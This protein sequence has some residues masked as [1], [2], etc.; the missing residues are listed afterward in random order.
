MGTETVV[1]DDPALTAR[2]ADDVPVARQPLRVVMG[3]RELDPGRRV[4][5]TAAETVVI[6]TRDPLAALGELWARGCRRVLLEGGPT[7]AAAFL[8]AG[9]VDEVIVYIAPKFLGAGRAA[10][11]DLGVTTISEA[12]EGDVTDITVL[13]SGAGEAPNVRITLRPRPR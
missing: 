7:I 6:R 13:E 3:L 1:V 5:D 9:V 8:R 10:V 11:A 2:D 12:L 4:F